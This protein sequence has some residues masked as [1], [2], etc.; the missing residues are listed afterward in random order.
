MESVFRHDDCLK[1]LIWS[2][3]DRLIHEASN[4]SLHRS[5]PRICGR[6]VQTNSGR[7]VFYILSFA[8]TFPHA[9]EIIWSQMDRGMGGLGKFME[10][11]K[12]VFEFNET[13][14]RYL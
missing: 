6:E 8:K 9:I 5:G 1:I 4:L 12:L 14:L 11:I 13:I 3:S 7:F 10:F 2:Q